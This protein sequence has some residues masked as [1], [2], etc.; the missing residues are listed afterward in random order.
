MQSYV[1]Q[2]RGVMDPRSITT[3]GVSSKE[4]KSPIGFFGTGLKYAIAVLLRLKCDITIHSGPKT[5][6]FSVK[7]DTLRVNEF[8]FIYMDSGDGPIPLGYTT[9]LGKTWDIWQAFRELACNTMD[10]NG[11]YY[12]TDSQPPHETTDTTIVVTGL[13]FAAAWAE[14]QDILLTDRAPTW[15]NENL[16]IYPGKSRWIYYRG[17][18]VY[19]TPRPT[20]QTYNI[21]SDMYL[22][23]DRTFKNSFIA[24]LRIRNAITDEVQ[25]ESV[26]NTAVLASPDMEWESLQDFDSFTM[27]QTFKTVVGRHIQAMTRGLNHYAE[28]AVRRGNMR[29][30]MP[31]DTHK[32]DFVEKQRLTAAIQFCRKI[33]F[34]VDE[35]AIIVSESLGVGV[36]GRAHDKTIYVSHICFRQGTKMLAGTLIEEFLHLKHGCQDCT[37]D[38]QNI[39]MDTICSLGERITKKPL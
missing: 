3:F 26:I 8:D 25:D 11:S 21:L 23:E 5:Y 17:V 35:F 22:T 27:S 12:T 36:L 19:K 30:Y 1:F 39:L 15:Q 18:R 2:N 29:Q 24:D 16:A 10:E 13:P 32:L 20:A 7:R 31:D 28:N 37:R 6:R 34:P 9:E 33:G 4:N 38:M 14:R